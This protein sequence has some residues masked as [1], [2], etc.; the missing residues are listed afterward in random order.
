M[1]KKKNKSDVKV[2]SMAE[3]QE[4]GVFRLNN[5]NFKSEKNR[6]CHISKFMI[7]HAIN[8]VCPLVVW[9]SVVYNTANRDLTLL[10]PVMLII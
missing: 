10:M 4:Q 5:W 3:L 1:S 2:K 8:T 6:W 7:T 9:H